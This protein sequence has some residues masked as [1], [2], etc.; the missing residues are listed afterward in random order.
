MKNPINKASSLYI[1][2]AI[3]LFNITYPQNAKSQV[4]QEI[5]DQG[6]RTNEQIIRQERRFI[7][8]E[9]LRLRKDRLARKSEIIN[10]KPTLPKEFSAIDESFC[11]EIKEIKLSGANSLLKRDKKK[12]T[13]NYLEKCLNVQQIFQILNDI[14]S[15]Y[16]A[17]GMVSARSYISPDQSI[18]DKTLNIIVHEGVIE[19]IM[20]NDNS[21]ERKIE[22]ISAFPL[23]KNRPLNIRD[24][25]QGLDQINRLPSNNA[26]LDIEPS[27]K[28]VGHSRVS[29]KNA[30]TFRTRGSASYDNMCSDS[31]GRNCYRFSL[32]HDNLL[33]LN[34]Q[35]YL[36]LS[37]YAGKRKK[38]RDSQSAYLSL[39]IPFGYWTGQFSTSRSSYHSTINGQVKSFINHGNSQNYNL[40]LERLVSRSKNHK[41]TIKFGMEVKD[42]ESFIE[43]VALESGTKK[44]SIANLGISHYIANSRGY[45]LIN[46]DYLQGTTLFGAKQDQKESN[47]LVQR[48]QYEALKLY[49]SNYQYFRTFNLSNS[50]TLSGQ[51]SRHTLFGSEQFSIGDP[52][53]VRGFRN[54]AASGDHGLFIK[55]NLSYYIPSSKHEIIN[56]IFSNTKPFIGIDGGMV[57]SREKISSQ[58]NISKLAG[59]TIGIDKKI[60]IGKF[61]LNSSLTYSRALMASKHIKKNDH[62]LY[63]NLK[64]D[65]F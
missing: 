59:A 3:T 19:E 31:T 15:Y 34:D 33:F 40:G 23:L 30:T 61:S 36:S 60:K 8:E 29:I 35:L 2:L 58:K 44:L 1:I 20:I 45:N 11:L 6:S 48:A 27:Q 26:T 28:N 43:D 37:E 62:E 24:I 39:S 64:L 21:A 57:R 56:Y 7:E 14:N 16:I 17:K 5:I 18:K 63:F 41:T 49:F 46:I 54:G 53:S 4:P 42:S 50:F 52:Y 51:Y 65:A 22:K 38:A 55:N 12:I 13:K 47:S 32:Q 25:E 9:S 10:I